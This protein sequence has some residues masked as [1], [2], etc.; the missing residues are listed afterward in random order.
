MNSAVFTGLDLIPIMTACG[1][2]LFALRLLFDR[3][4]HKTTQRLLSLFFLMIFVEVLCAFLTWNP[5][6]RTYGL[7]MSPLVVFASFVSISLK[8]PALYLYVSTMQESQERL[9]PQD[10]AHL[11]WPFV[12]GMIIVALGIELKDMIAPTQKG[13][14]L[15]EAIEDASKI[16]P[17]LYAIAAVRLL[18]KTKNKLKGFYANGTINLPLIPSLLVFGFLASW[19]WRMVARGL[20]SFV[21]DNDEFKPFP[22]HIGNM[23][24]VMLI[25]SLFFFSTSMMYLRLAKAIDNNNELTDA[26]PDVKFVRR[27]DTIMN[28][29]RVLKLHLDKDMNIDR[30]ARQI[31]CE[32]K[33]VSMVL[34]NEM[35]T[36]FFDFI[37]HHRV[38]HAKNLL[39]NDD[40]LNMMGIMSRS[41]FNSK[42]N[43]Y[44]VFKKETGGTPSEFRKTYSSSTQSQNDGHLSTPASSPNPATP[45]SEHTDTNIGKSQHTT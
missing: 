34:K 25:Y 33:D 41:G 4:Q 43:F 21:L 23:L 19:V 35:S 17:I 9:R 14:A 31:E 7:T 37:N 42:S 2:L 8:G 44:R 22:G 20:I 26:V 6:F 10:I 5:H 11:I 40:E 39:A 45:N 12:A 18:H 24:D 15:V 16:A 30:F 1:S 36:N 3:S 28:G 27:L 32:A 13:F 38:E 29:I